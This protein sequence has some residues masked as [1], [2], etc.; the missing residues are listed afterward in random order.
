M[1][2]YFVD[3]EFTGHIEVEAQ[4]EE[5]DKEAVE[6]MSLMSLQGIFITSI[7]CSEPCAE[8]VSALIQGWQALC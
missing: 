6:D 3:F 7:A 1:P 2:K 5:E 4:N 8:L